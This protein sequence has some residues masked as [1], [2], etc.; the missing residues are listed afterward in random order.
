M[1]LFSA[2]GFITF[3]KFILNVSLMRETCKVKYNLTNQ[4]LTSYKE[5]NYYMYF[6]EG[7]RF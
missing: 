6:H 3:C 1:H 5:N 7:D 4:C 2:A